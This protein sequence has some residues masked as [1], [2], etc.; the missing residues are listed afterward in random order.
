[1]EDVLFLRHP[2]HFNKLKSYGL[3]LES[4]EWADVLKE[5]TVSFEGSV[6]GVNREKVEHYFS[7]PEIRKFRFGYLTLPKQMEIKNAD[8]FYRLMAILIPLEETA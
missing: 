1:M 4:E 8:D 7:D 5:L 6:L 3:D 2:I